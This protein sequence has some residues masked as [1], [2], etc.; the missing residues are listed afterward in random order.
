ML[1]FRLRRLLK[2]AGRELVVLWYACRHP[3]TPLF[4]KLAS[5][6]LALYFFSPIDLVPDSL[7]LLGWF[8]DVALLAMAIPALVRRVPASVLRDVRVQAER[9]LAKLPILRDR[10]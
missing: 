1:L 5:I 10:A 4:V 9:L 3:D 2:T 7:L 6:L 8:D